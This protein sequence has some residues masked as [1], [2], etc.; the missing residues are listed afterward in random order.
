MGQPISRLEG[1]AAVLGHAVFT[2]D[3]QGSMIFDALIDQVVF[4]LMVAVEGKVTG[5][6]ATDDQGWQYGKCQHGL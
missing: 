2:G 3:G 4:Q 5:D 1:F 6:Q